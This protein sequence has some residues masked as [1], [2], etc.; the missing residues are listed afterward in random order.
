MR[1]LS[2][3]EVM[4]S[5]CHGKI[6]IVLLEKKPKARKFWEEKA[7]QLIRKGDEGPK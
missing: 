6:A 7:K 5:P 3:S 2:L 4:I 1:V